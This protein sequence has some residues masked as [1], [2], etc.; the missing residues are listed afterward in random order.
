MLQAIHEI[1]SA[2]A[3]TACVGT[4]H[5]VANTWVT[6]VNDAL[7][8][9]ADGEEGQIAISGVQLARGYLRH[10]ELTACKFVLA[11]GDGRRYYLTGDLAVRTSD[12]RVQ[13]RGRVDSQAPAAVPA[14]NTATVALPTRSSTARLSWIAPLCRSS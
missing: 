2:S 5:S 8:P 10:D 3:A 4:G 6:V 11:D 12:G 7:Q 13:Y 9:C 1:T 14:R